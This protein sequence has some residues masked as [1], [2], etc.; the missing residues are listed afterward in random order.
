MKKIVLRSVFITGAILAA[1]AVIFGGSLMVSAAGLE[2]DL[3]ATGSLTINGGIFQEFQLDSSTGTGTFHP[4]LH[5]SATGQGADVVE[6]YSTD[7]EPPQYDET[8]QWTHALPLADLPIVQEGGIYYREF[9][10]DSN[11]SGS[12]S[13]R[14]LTW[15]DL[16][17]YQTNNNLIQPYPTAFGIPGTSPKIW[18]LDAGGE[19]DVYITFNGLF[20]SGSGDGDVRILIPDSVFSHSYTYVIAYVKFG[21]PATHPNND[22]FE[23]FGYIIYPTGNIIVDKVTIPTGA[24]QSFEFNPSW[25]A[26][27]FFLTD[28]GT[29]VDSGPLTAGTYSVSEI[30]PAGWD[31][32]G[33]VASDGSPVN[34][35]S[36]QGGETITV[37]FTNT[38]RGTVTIVKD[39]IPNDAQDFTYTGF[40]GFSLDDDADGTLLNTITFNNVL[41]GTYDVVEGALA[42]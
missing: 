23:E 37:T 17:L 7:Y 34:A 8:A 9:V 35:L 10:L 1:T 32:T 15:E 2:K 18:D 4:F 28:A 42:N 30:V 29:P 31:L 33:A 12:P 39:A 20:S 6:G 38:K 13:G 40:G 19:G 26:T 16:E 41:P 3:R 25:S 36:L 5:V 11:Q 22:G 27:N 14:L 21:D 24:S